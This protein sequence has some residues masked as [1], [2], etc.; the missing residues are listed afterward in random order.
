M[1]EALKLSN[2]TDAE[3]AAIP[4]PQGDALAN[5]MQFG[6]SYEAVA[7]ALTIPIGTVK[8]RINRARTKIAAARAL[9]AQA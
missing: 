3:L 9:A 5:Y 2:V 7:V 6:S 1:R 8:S 4:K